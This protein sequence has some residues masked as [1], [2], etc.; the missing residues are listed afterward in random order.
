[1][2]SVCKRL[3]EEGVKYINCGG[4]ETLGLNSF[5]GK[6]QP[7]KSIQLFSANVSYQRQGNDNIKTTT[8]V[9]PSPDTWAPTVV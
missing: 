4:S 5:K 3:Q 9:S 1:M 7:V 6:F 8:I 2:V